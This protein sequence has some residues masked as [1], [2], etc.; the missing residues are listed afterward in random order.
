MKVNKLRGKTFVLILGVMYLLAISFGAWQHQSELKKTLGEGLAST[1]Q[2]ISDSFNLSP[3]EY[4]HLLGITYNELIMSDLNRRFNSLVKNTMENSGVIY[5]YIEASLHDDYKHTVSESD[6]ALYD[7]NEGTPLNIIYLLDAVNNRLLNEHGERRTLLDKER[8]YHSLNKEYLKKP[9]S[10]HLIHKDKWGSYITGIA[11]FYLTD[12]TYVGVLGVDYDYSIFER[13][14]WSYWVFLTFFFM[15]SI[16]PLYFL[17]KHID[18]N[19]KRKESIEKLYEV[20]N[21]DFL[22]GVLN[23]RAIWSYL[24]NQWS[25]CF[26]NKENISIIIIDIDYFKEYNDNYG[27]LAGDKILVKI[28]KILKG[29]ILDYDGE[30]GRY[31]GDEF[32]IILNN[33]PLDAL[34]EIVEKIERDIRCANIEHAFS[35]ISSRQTLSMGVATCIPNEDHDLYHLFD[36]ADKSLY[37]A[38]RYGRNSTVIS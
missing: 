9:F 1:A 6:Y 29:A 21:I 38:K 11:P 31:G 10:G 26:K 37:K 32:L 2:I 23:R 36:K 18:L 5:V 13:S 20:S 28:S 14:M 3:S 30:V 7:A 22:T 15:I 34:Q 17:Y 12:G 24:E 33:C 8:Y 35:P 4:E 25:K 16:I 27:H 19:H